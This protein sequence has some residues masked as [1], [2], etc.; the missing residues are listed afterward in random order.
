MAHRLSRSMMAFA[1]A[2]SGIFLLGSGAVQAQGYGR[3]SG[4]GG[5]SGQQSARTSSALRSTSQNAVLQ[6]LYAQQAGQYS[7]NQLQT[8]ALQLAL[9]KANVQNALAQLVA[10]QQSGQLG[11]SQL[12]TAA[13]QQT[14]LQSYLNQINAVQQTGAVTTAQLLA[15]Q[16]QLRSLNSGR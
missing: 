1:L 2:A 14:V 3:S 9:L 13:Q 11:T 15:L 10:L 8:A 7:G 6:Q 4:A 12:Q 16:Q 5:C